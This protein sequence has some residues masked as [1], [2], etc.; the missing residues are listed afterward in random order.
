MIMVVSSKRN[1]VLDRI[2]YLDL[3]SVPNITEKAITVLLNRFSEPSSI[4]KAEKKE[5]EA[6]GLSPTLVSRITGYER[7]RELIPRLEAIFDNGVKMLTREDPGYPS[8]IKDFT[9]PPP[10]IFVWGD[11]LEED[12]NSIGIIGTRRASSYGRTTC[13][14]FSRELARAG[15]TIVS[16]LARGIDTLA[17]RTAIEVNGRTVAFLGCGIDVI[18]PPEN[19]GLY[20]EIARQGAVISEFP[21]AT[22]PYKKNFIK[23]N[24]LIPAFSKAIL[25]VEAPEKSGVLNTVKWAVEMGKDVMVIPG[26][27]FSPKSSGTNQLIKDGAIPVTSAE[28]ILEYLNLTGIETGKREIKLSC[29]EEKILKHIE[30]EPKHVDEIVLACGLELSQISGVLLSLEMKKVIRQLPGGCYIR[31]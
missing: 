10:V 14:Y 21:P 8:W 7:D 3:L 9:F 26:N 13:E 29:E 1:S 20:A 17:H 31:R 24:R 27:I 11:L 2:S 15:V 28:D 19:K 6:L 16:G 12:R 4:F 22:P 30:A 25:A 5:L 18:Y 23:R